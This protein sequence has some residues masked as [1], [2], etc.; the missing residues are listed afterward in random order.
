MEGADNHST[1]RAGPPEPQ[2]RGPQSQDQGCS[3]Q[4]AAL[5]TPHA[6]AREPLSHVRRH[7]RHNL[8]QTGRFRHNLLGGRRSHPQTDLQ[9]LP[10]SER[11]FVASRTAVSSSSLTSRTIRRHKTETDK[12]T[13]PKPTEMLDIPTE[14]HDPAI[15]FWP[16]RASR[17]ICRR[18][19][20]AAAR[21]PPTSAS[22]PSRGLLVGTRR[23][24]TL[25]HHGH[26]PLLSMPAGD[27][28][29][30]PLVER[31]QRPVAELIA[32]TRRREGV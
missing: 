17:S 21:G 23:W 13:R 1:Q 6:T 12:M 4:R 30:Q 26:R 2:A 28:A 5:R 14:M 10:R 25:C 18:S 8:L 20:L 16:S 3:A 31:E 19:A 22:P 27:R 29:L 15:A 11:R 24:A 9:P 7:G 32:R